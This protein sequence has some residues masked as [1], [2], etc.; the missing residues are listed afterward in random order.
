MLA[1]AKDRLMLYSADQTELLRSIQY[2][3]LRGWSLKWQ[4]GMLEL[5]VDRGLGAAVA[6]ETQKPSVVR[7]QC[8]SAD[9]RI[10]N[11][12]IGG[13]IFLS[14]RSSERSQTLDEELFYKL[15]SV[16]RLAQMRTTPTN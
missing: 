1:V 12:F 14:L 4:A 15:T 5:D 2:S 7:L 3:A 8:V 6:G 16:K 9:A 13:Y 11:E 10:L